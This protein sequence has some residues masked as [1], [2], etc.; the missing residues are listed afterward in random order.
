MDS[1]PNKQR[2]EKF[3]KENNLTIEMEDCI[4]RGVR[5]GWVSVD[6]PD[7]LITDQGNCGRFSEWDGADISKAEIWL[8]VQEMMDDLVSC[9]WMT[10][11]QYEAKEVN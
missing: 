7:G 1:K 2:C 8:A 4:F 3:A 10:T 11:E 5:T 9:E 6:L